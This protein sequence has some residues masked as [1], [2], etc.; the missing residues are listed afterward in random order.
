MKTK[1][2]MAAVQMRGDV[3]LGEVLKTF[4]IQGGQINFS[5]EDIGSERY[6]IQQDICLQI[7]PEDITISKQL[8]KIFRMEVRPAV[9]ETASPIRFICPK[10][11]DIKVLEFGWRPFGKKIE[12][13]FLVNTG[14]DAFFCAIIQVRGEKYT[15]ANVNDVSGLHEY[16]DSF[17]EYKIQQM[18]SVVN[19]DK[20]SSKT[21]AVRKL[22]TRISKGDY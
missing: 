11:E 14:K 5:F 19:E 3:I 6:T 20:R 13:L 18:L 2:F 12:R 22:L 17:T 4:L 21:V 1:A 8:S 7:A 9:R 15:F 10:S 16:I